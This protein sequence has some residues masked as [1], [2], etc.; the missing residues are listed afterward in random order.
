M[1]PDPT[2]TNTMPKKSKK[3]VTKWGHNGEA[4]L[5]HT[6]AKQKAKGNWGDNNPK[7]LAWTACVI[8]LAGSERASGRTPKTLQAIKSRWQH[9]Y[10]TPLL[11]G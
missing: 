1:H 10:P 7:M 4:M 5:V 9:V 11:T 6:L 8:S 3:N 2:S